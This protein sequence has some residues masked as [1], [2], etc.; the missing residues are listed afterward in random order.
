VCTEGVPSTACWRLLDALGGADV[1]WRNDFDWT[2]LR[3]TAGALDRVAARPWRMGEPDYADALATGDT[4]PL[5]GTPAPSPWDPAL[6][7][8]L[9]AAGRSVMEERLVGRLLADLEGR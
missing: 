3:I 7:A 5:R 4:E 9:A 8:A 6:A 2:G 1:W